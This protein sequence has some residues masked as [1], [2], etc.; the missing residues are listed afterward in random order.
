MKFDPYVHE[1]SLRGSQDQ[2][3]VTDTTAVCLVAISLLLLGLG[4][5]GWRRA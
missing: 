5:A 4:W 1:L 2:R 3:N